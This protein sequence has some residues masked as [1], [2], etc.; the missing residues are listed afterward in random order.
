MIWVI[1]AALW[2]AAEASFFFIVPDVLLTAAALRLGLRRALMLCLVAATSAVLTGVVMWLWAAH[3]PMMA[4]S[5]MLRVPAV[6]PDLLARVHGEFDQGWPRHML[7]GAMT[8]VPY[9]LYAV[10]AGSRHISLLH[11]VPVSVIVRLFRFVLT[12]SLVSAAGTLLRRLNRPGLVKPLWVATWCLVY[13]I[14]FTE[15]FRAS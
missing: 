5:A 14:Y 9:K 15:R 11:F 10:E 4:R 6:G 12:A 3:D 13:L 2:G 1:G 8:G 7:L